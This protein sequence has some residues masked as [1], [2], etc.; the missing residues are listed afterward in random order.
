[1]RALRGV[2]VS[3]ALLAM[4]GLVGCK[5]DASP[6]PGSQS[7]PSAAPSAAALDVSVLPGAPT[8]ASIVGF[9]VVPQGFV[10]ASEEP[11]ATAGSGYWFASDT[12]RLFWGDDASD[13]R[14]IAKSEA[15]GDVLH[16]EL[17]GSELLVT[18]RNGGIAVRTGEDDA[19]V[20][21][22]RATDEEAR[23]FEKREARAAAMLGRA[24]EKALE[25]CIAAKAKTL[26][27]EDD[28]KA[29]M[30]P[31]EMMRCIRAIDLFKRKS[32]AAGGALPECLPDK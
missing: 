5:S 1:M 22:R 27:N 29:L 24:C 32:I 2:V 12:V 7:A 30:G 11:G 26:A 8:L 31:P 21:L 4:V 15:K 3:S 19:P 28:C 17:E 16:V 20:P 9:W 14:A 13:R 6:R 25:C 10:P 18:R 23:A